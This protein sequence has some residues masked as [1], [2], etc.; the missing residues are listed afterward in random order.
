MSSLN[1]IPFVADEYPKQYL[2]RRIVRAKLYI[3]ANF[4]SAIDLSSI[5]DEACLSKFHFARVFRSVYGRTPHRYLT[6]RRLEAAKS[7]L[8][9]GKPVTAVCF[10]T[11]FESVPSFTNLF[12][13]FVGT[14]PA[15]FQRTALKRSAETSAIPLSAVPACFAKTSY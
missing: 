8:A 15:E 10:A 5:A 12:K 9:D 2:Y 6:F 13:R 11:G 1:K 7:M 4:A 14:P 3:D